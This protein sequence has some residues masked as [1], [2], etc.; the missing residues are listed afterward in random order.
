[1]EVH[2]TGS[3]KRQQTGYVDLYYEHRKNPFQALVKALNALD[4]RGFRGHI[5]QQGGTMADWGRRK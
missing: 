1:M 3:L 4:I 2:L 5:E